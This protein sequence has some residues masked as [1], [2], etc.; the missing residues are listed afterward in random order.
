MQRQTVAIYARTSKEYKNVERISIDQQVEDARR[1]AQTKNLPGE[2][3]PYI[4]PDRSGSL[5]ARQWAEGQRRYR[6]NF[7]SLVADIQAGKI[8]CL[9]CRKLDRLA[10]GTEMTLRLLRL[11]ATHKVR[12]LATDETLPGAD[13]DSGMFT[14][15][16]LAAAAEYEL[17]KISSNTR[18]ALE[19]IRRHGGKLGSAGRTLGYRDAGKGKVDVDPKTDTVVVE[20]FNRYVGGESLSSI[21]KWLTLVVAQWRGGQGYNNSHVTRM[22]TNV[23]YIGMRDYEGKLEPSKVH[24]SI[25]DP[26]IFWQANEILKNRKGVHVG[27]PTGNKAPHLLSGLLKCGSCGRNMR[28]KTNRGG[29]SAACNQR[30]DAGFSQFRMNEIAWLEWAESFFAPMMQINREPVSNPDRALALTKLERITAN[31]GNLQAKFAS[32][33]LNADLLAGAL[34]LAT[35][36]RDKV[37]QQLDAMPPAD[38][39]TYKAWPEMTFDEKRR[40]LLRMIER[41]DIHADKVTVTFAKHTNRPPMTFPLMLRRPVGYRGKPLNCLTPCR[42][43]TPEASRVETPDGATVNWQAYIIDRRGDRNAYKTTAQFYHANPAHAAVPPP[44]RGLFSYPTSDG[45]VFKTESGKVAGQLLATRLTKRL[46]LAGCEAL[47]ATGPDTGN[48][49]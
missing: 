41:V 33:D 19:Y 26:A 4:D 14:L 9:I 40:A 21:A 23:H 12:L 5:P 16:I 28:W 32:G 3:Q 47:A 44:K 22:L 13:D 15:T 45:K 49:K 43:T 48:G 6:E 29:F 35:V 18:R 2:V 31:I 7:T 30:H 39:P 27:N 36:E 8:S 34:E 38:H 24:P 25:I 1:L 11:L 17:K 37:Q 42:L 46:T 20:M 10:R